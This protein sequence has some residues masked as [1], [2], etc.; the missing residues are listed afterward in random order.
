ME[1]KIVIYNY[2]EFA[3]DKGFSDQIKPFIK[4]DQ[5]REYRAINYAVFKECGGISAF[6]Y[7][8]DSKTHL[9]MSIWNSEEDYQKW[10]HHPKIQP[11]LKL[12]AGYH[13]QHNITEKLEGPYQATEYA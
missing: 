7:F 8:V 10:R 11:Y 4:T 9:R 3:N 12:R 2:Y 13:A 5:A 1:K 6:D